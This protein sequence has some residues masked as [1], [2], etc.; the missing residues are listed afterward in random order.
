MYLDQEA[1]SIKV[2]QTDHWPAVIV[3]N[4]P[5]S[6]GK[7]SI[8]RLLQDSLP[9]PYLRVG[10][11]RI[12]DQMPAWT[13]CLD[14][15][16]TSGTRPSGFFFEQTE[17]GEIALGVG[18]YGRALLKSYYA[19]LAL[20]VEQGIRLIVDDV[21]LGQESF[22]LLLDALGPWRPLCIGLSASAELLA[23][24]ERARGDRMHGSAVWQAAG[25][26]SGIEYDLRLDTTSLSADAAAD[27]IIRQITTIS[28]EPKGS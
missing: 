7:T 23:K 13:N 14:A 20:M 11:D 1:E 10:T 15:I 16:T 22:Q 8:T 3:L 27:L 26:H 24:R 6:V 21:W 17:A 12:I 18:D 25:V 5:S 9:V 19:S 2:S 28:R 4:G